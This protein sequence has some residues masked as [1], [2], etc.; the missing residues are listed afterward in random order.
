MDGWF[1]M[2]ERETKT[3]NQKPEIKINIPETSGNTTTMD[4]MKKKSSVPTDLEN[5]AGILL[6][7]Q[8]LEQ[9]V[10]STKKKISKH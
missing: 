1:L 7:S 4:S 3:Q 8:C 10:P 6:P 5:L 2:R 9:S